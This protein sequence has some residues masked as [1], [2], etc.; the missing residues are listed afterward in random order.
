M[1]SWFLQ[2]ADFMPHGMCLL[3]RPGLMALHV[4]SDGWIAAAYFAI[5]VGIAFFVQRRPDLNVQHK[6]L[7]VLFALF[8]AACGATHLMSILVLW[9]PY[10]VAEGVLKA[11]TALLSVATAATLVFL[12]PQVLR[13]PSPKTLAAEIDAHKATLLELQAARQQ[14]AEQVTLAEGDLQ[15]TTRR[16]EVALRDS[17]ITVFEQDENFRYTWIYNPPAGL[18]AADFIGKTEFDFFSADSAERAQAFKAQALET[19][20]SQ[21]GEVNM[22][23]GAEGEWFD[24]RVEPI[25]LRSGGRGL[26]ATSTDIT[27]L[28]RQQDHLHV[29]MR[30]LN[31][32]CK[33]LLTVVVS[34]ARQTARGFDLPKDFVAQLQERLTSLASAHDVLASQ[35]WN[36]ADLRCIVE[37]QLRHQLQAF[38]ERMSITGEPVDLPAEAAHYVGMALHELGSNA[39]KH[40]ALSGDRGSVDISW[41]VSGAPDAP[42]LSLV[43][44]ENLDGP[45]TPPTRQGFGT[46]ILTSLTPNAVGGKAQLTFAEPGLE[47]TLAARLQP[48]AVQVAPLSA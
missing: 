9:K 8:I 10:Y 11:V 46:R 24:L 15:E 35:N 42:D 48:G 45:M 30:E 28:K 20:A 4:L 14:L 34:I 37:G 1:M 5:P 36:G 6:A 44:R 47:W 32:R 16:F 12:I 7:A 27:P 26:I 43:W 3:W 41:T 13:I 17:P 19:G 25:T 23:R 21:R 18:T 38:G 2:V 22:T 29:V 33:N 40:G 31:H 39:V